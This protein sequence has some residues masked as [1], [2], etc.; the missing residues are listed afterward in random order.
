MHECSQK[1]TKVKVIR[2]ESEEDFLKRHVIVTQQLLEDA[3]QEVIFGM[4][5]SFAKGRK[6]ERCN[7]IIRKDCITTAGNVI[8]PRDDIMRKFYS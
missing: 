7:K 4:H 6:E 2:L 3:S 1:Y 5:I 8:D